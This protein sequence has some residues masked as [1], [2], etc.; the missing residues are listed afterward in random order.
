M[1]FILL[2]ISEPLKWEYGWVEGQISRCF[3]VD[4]FNDVE[5]LHFGAFSYAMEQ[6]S[7]LQ[8]ALCTRV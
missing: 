8:P 6:S 7:V 4:A 1:Y 5:M 3:F 2:Q